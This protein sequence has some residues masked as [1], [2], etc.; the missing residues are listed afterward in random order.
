MGQEIQK[1]WLCLNQG[2]SRPP[3]FKVAGCRV[4]LSLLGAVS[5]GSFAADSDTLNT[6]LDNARTAMA[7][8]DLLAQACI[9]SRQLTDSQTADSCL[10]FNQALDGELLTSYLQN[11]RDARAWRE[12]YISSP[13]TGSLDQLETDTAL[14]LMVDIERL[15]GEGALLKRT[16]YVAPAYQQ[17]TSIPSGIAGDLEALRQESLTSVERS[18]LR[19][20]LQQQQ[21]RQQ[22]EIQRQFDR[23]ELELIRQQNQPGNPR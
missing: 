10:V 14:Q 6:Q 1:S 20:S 18:Q 4:L 11:C 15:C 8:M 19:Q 12:D 5:I 9:E 16:R 22:Q 3:L 2:S 21:Q 17:T 13:E 7:E 23:L